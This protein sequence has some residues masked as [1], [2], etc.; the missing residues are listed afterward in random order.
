MKILFLSIFVFI[1]ATTTSYSQNVKEK[2]N[3]IEVYYSVC[4]FFD[5][6]ETNWTVLVPGT[7]H[8]DG[9]NGRNSD[10]KNVLQLP[11]TFGINYS[12]TFRNNDRIRLSALHYYFSYNNESLQP[13]DVMNRSYG[14]YSLGYL[15]HIFGNKNKRFIAIGELNYRNGSETVHIYFPYRWDN[16]VES[17]ILSDIGLSAGLRIERNLPLNFI[18]SGEAKY[19]RFI[20]CHSEGVDFFGQHK[21]P[22]PNT[23]TLKFGLGY[24]F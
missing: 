3:K 2:R 12:R 24:Q 19:S 17:L 10:K 7:K 13:G 20:Y 4:H 22:T 6:T 1:S 9:P 8:I 14:L 21:D 15:H 18:L 11:I 5:G 23:L 16:R